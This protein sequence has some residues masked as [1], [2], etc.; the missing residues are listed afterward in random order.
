MAQKSTACY[1]IG[2]NCCSVSYRICKNV[3][4]RLHEFVPAAGNLRI[5]LLP[6]S[7]FESKVKYHYFCLYLWQYSAMFSASSLHPPFLRPRYK[8]LNNS[9]K[10][11]FLLSRIEKQHVQ[12][13]VAPNPNSVDAVHMAKRIGK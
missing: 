11:N 4:Q 6:S 12:F 10:F 1:C 7:A 5:K 9:I 3:I 8:E 2:Q 13:H